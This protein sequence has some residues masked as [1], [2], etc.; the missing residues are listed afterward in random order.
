MSWFQVNIF[1]TVLLMMCILGNKWTLIIS[2]TNVNLN[3]IN[4]LLNPFYSNISFEN[5]LPTFNI[6]NP[7]L[8]FHITSAPITTLS[9]QPH[10]HQSLPAGSMQTRGYY[11]MQVVHIYKRSAYDTIIGIARTSHI[12]FLMQLGSRGRETIYL[13]EFLEERQW[14]LVSQPAMF[15]FS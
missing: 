12:V 5:F 15:L 7:K 14:R 10:G 6:S 13:H 3:T 4:I 2:H 11:L 8:I 1:I 9:P